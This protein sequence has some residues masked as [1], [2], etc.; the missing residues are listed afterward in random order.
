VRFGDGS[1]SAS[2]YLAGMLWTALGGLR[3]ACDG[4]RDGCRA[5]SSELKRKLKYDEAS[6]SA[7]HPYHARG[8]ASAH[9]PRCAHWYHEYRTCCEQEHGTRCK[10]EHGTC[11]EQESR[12]GVSS[13]GEHR[14]AFSVGRAAGCG[15]PRQDTVQCANG[16]GFRFF[17]HQDTRPPAI[18]GPSAAGCRAERSD[19][20]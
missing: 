16:S 6:R 17:I 13:R 18:N 5:G 9:G 3:N 15:R 20:E 1:A 4:A 11:C 12:A 2:L 14:G 8:A 7:R 10:Q 19:R